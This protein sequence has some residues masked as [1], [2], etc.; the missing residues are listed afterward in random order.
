MYVTVIVLIV[1]YIFY[2][3]LECTRFEP[4]PNK[5]TNA[6]T[7]TKSMSESACRRGIKNDRLTIPYDHNLEIRWFD[8]IAGF[9][10]LPPIETRI[11]RRTK[12]PRCHSSKQKNVL[13]NAT[14]V[15]RAKYRYKNEYFSLPTCF[16][17][18][19]YFKW[20]KYC[21]HFHSTKLRRHVDLCWLFGSK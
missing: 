19:F 6:P 10:V 3:V 9:I 1:R 4:F 2:L 16:Y 20:R 15:L 17:F 18:Y 21:F 7:K 11:C 14:V 13:N 5:T 12:P 8:S